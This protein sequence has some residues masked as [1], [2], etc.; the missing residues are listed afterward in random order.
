M[1]TAQNVIP[2]AQA[3]TN[4][5][6]AILGR[7]R[8]L[9]RR[10][11][12]GTVGA[13]VL[14]QGFAVVQGI[15][16]ARLLGPSGRGEYATVV[17]WP[18]V[19]AAIGIFGTNI[20]LARAAAKTDQYDAVVRT[21]VLLAIIT[22]SIAGAACYFS[23]PHLLP[24][25][26]KHLLGLSRSFVIFI[27]LNHLGL[28]VIAVDQG[29]GNFRRFNVNRI[30]LHLFYVAFLVVLWMCDIREVKWPVVGLLLANLLA[31]LARLFLALKDMRLWGRL[32]SPVHTIRQSARFGL[33]GMA[34]PL[35]QQVDKALLLWLL[36]VENLGLYV[37]ALSASAV[38][39][40]IT[41]SV[42]MVSF[43]VAAQAER[44]HG[45][46]G[47]ARMFRVSTL[48]SLIPGSLL[49]L[50]MPILLPLVYG[51]EFV[52]S[53]N[54]ARVLVVGSVLAGLAN[55]LDQTLTG[56]GRAF[57]GLEARVAGLVVMTGLGYTLSRQW[58]L[59][60]MCLAFGLCQ[61]ACLLVFLS[62]VID[63]YG[64]S[65][66]AIRA[67]AIKRSDVREVCLRLRRAAVAASSL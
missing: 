40:S 27:I 41:S 12:I 52:S 48:L 15:I 8:R 47:V 20:A 62:R 50:A 34:M 45:F 3:Q 5:C 36:G 46:E 21:S 65:V 17:L 60:G 28:N 7:P 66:H 32:H 37:V 13:S 4:P 1:T 57:V 18:S 31:V 33:V 26:E 59:M 11:F 55:V 19:F 64:Q 51:S 30:L 56:Q 35:Y 2:V 67:F 29:A 39:G 6:E 61:L 42:G 38:I 43:T 25:A 58:G 22:S 16:I 49:A 24:E 9:G 44:G 54:P 14:L 23:L 10:A 53:V 63:H